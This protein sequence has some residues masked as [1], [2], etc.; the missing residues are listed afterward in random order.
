MQAP[1]GTR[2]AEF[3]STDDLD[4]DF[5]V[6]T[7]I[8]ATAGALLPSRAEDIAISYM[9]INIK[10]QIPQGQDTPLQFH[11]L[12][13]DCRIFFTPQTFWNFTNIWKYAA[14]AVYTNPEY[15]VTNSTGYGYASSSNN[16]LKPS[17]LPPD[18]ASSNINPNIAYNISGIIELSNSTNDFPASFSGQQNAIVRNSFAKPGQLCG[19]STPN[20]PGCPGGGFQCITV[21]SCG[22]AAER[23]V[24]TCSTFNNACGGFKCIFTGGSQTLTGKANNFGKQYQSGYCP[25]S[26]SDCRASVTGPNGF[27]PTT[28]PSP[29][30][31]S[32]NRKSGGTRDEYL[33]EGNIGGIVEAGLV[34]SWR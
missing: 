34:G 23:C 18:A 17:D 16:T 12:A 4:A 24:K 13:A 9:G 26:G 27:L 22:S 1:S 19:A 2:G 5:Q 33:A 6:T 3:Y 20:K 29:K 15:C 11:Y 8:N 28:I 30:Q 25:L 21:S 7:A 32:S 14:A 31:G 10:D